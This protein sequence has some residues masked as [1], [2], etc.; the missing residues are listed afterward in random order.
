M[1]IVLKKKKKQKTDVVRS[2][3]QSPVLLLKKDVK[4]D[5]NIQ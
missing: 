4:Y 2:W 5:F 3:V 1:M